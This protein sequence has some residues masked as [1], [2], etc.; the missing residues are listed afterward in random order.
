MLRTST[1]LNDKG[2][3]MAIKTALKDA[4]NSVA[5]LQLKEIQDIV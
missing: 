5:V 2:E 1:P 4:A 3:T